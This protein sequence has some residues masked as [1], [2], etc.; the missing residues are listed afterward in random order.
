MLLTA[1]FEFP[2][3]SQNSLANLAL[4]AWT[5]SLGRSLEVLRA[6]GN[7]GSFSWNFTR[8]TQSKSWRS[9][10]ILSTKKAAAKSLAPKITSGSALNSASIYSMNSGSPKSAGSGAGRTPN[11]F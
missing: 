7:C 9:V 10:K 3:A 11:S 6:S 8:S 5:S 2:L 4:I 1:S